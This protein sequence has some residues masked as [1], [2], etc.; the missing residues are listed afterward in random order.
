MTLPIVSMAQIL[1]RHPCTQSNPFQYAGKDW[2]GTALQILRH[3]RIPAEHKLWV[4]L[5]ESVLPREILIEAACCFAER[6]LAAIPHGE[7]D[8]RSIAA[9]RAARAYMRCEINAAEMAKSASAARAAARAAQARVEAAWEAA[10]EAA[11]AAADAAARA[12]AS[13]AASAAAQ[14][15]QVKIL[16]RLCREYSDATN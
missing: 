15:E 3:P 13:A 7:V 14:K 11:D 8:P 12:A 2:S 4:V 5:H 9:I 16:V 1:S 6:A 10:W